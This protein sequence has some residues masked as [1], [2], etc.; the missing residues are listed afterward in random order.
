VRTPAGSTTTGQVRMEAVISDRSF[1]AF[2]QQRPF[3]QTPSQE[4]HLLP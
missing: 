3:D 4:F 2:R 1:V